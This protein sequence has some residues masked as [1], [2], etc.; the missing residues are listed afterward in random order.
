MKILLLILILIL[1]SCNQ[2]KDSKAI[3]TDSSSNN[4]QS[5]II[6]NSSIISRFGASHIFS[7]E[8]TDIRLEFKRRSDMNLL[9]IL[10][11]MIP[12]QTKGRDILEYDPYNLKTCDKIFNIEL[13]KKNIS[14]FQ[15]DT[16]Y[17]LERI[18]KDQSYIIFIW[19]DTKTI[20]SMSDSGDITHLDYNEVAKE[21]DE[22]EFAYISSW[23]KD[24]LQEYG[25]CQEYDGYYNSNPYSSCVIRIILTNDSIILDMFKYYCPYWPY[26]RKR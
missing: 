22:N 8:N 1:S 21:R 5:S 11:L 10:R 23:L 20:T 4:S 19:H 2:V 6:T 3:E 9:S 14:D 12:S 25:C 26:E 18:N 15:S 13:F 17:A 16:I 7:E 24:E